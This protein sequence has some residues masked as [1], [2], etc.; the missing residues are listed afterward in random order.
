[1]G[2]RLC[3]RCGNRCVSGGAH[4]LIYKKESRIF[5]TNKIVIKI[6]PFLSDD[7]KRI[8]LSKDEHIL[9]RFL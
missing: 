3:V 1:M 5:Y 4:V 8:S 6:L 9:G 7:H 2:I